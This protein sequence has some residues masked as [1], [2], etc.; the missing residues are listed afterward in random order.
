MSC[1]MQA[2]SNKQVTHEQFKWKYLHEKK[3]KIVKNV[4]VGMLI[5]EDGMGCSG[6][7]I[8]FLAQVLV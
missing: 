4:V 2:W 1:A 7:T 5:M 6:Q 8:N 3:K